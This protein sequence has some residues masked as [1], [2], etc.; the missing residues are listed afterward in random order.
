[1]R[2]NAWDIAG[3]GTKH[4]LERRSQYGPSGLVGHR[5]TSTVPGD[6]WASTVP[7]VG[8][9]SKSARDRP[10]SMK[11]F[12][13]KRTRGVSLHMGVDFLIMKIC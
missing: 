3:K 11:L 9:G 1:M 5:W 8:P 6:C 12:V 2:R 4:R 7:G 10:Q 13:R